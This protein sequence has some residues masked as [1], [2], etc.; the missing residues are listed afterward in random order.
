MANDYFRF[1]QFTVAQEGCG[2][3][4]GTDGV[5][6]GAWVAVGA[7]EAMLDVGTGTGLI[8]LM[9][10]QRS[11]AV[12]DA[13]DVD[14]AAFRQARGNVSASPFAGR[15]KVYH[16]SLAAY[17]STAERRYDL[18]VSNPPYFV[19]SLKSPD[20]Q[21]TMAR[22]ADTLPLP[23]LVRDSLSLLT[24]NGRMAFI[25][26]SSREE[27]LMEIAGEYG[28]NRIRKTAVIP[29]PGALPK[30]FLVELSA[31]PSL[32]CSTGLLTLE[33]SR[34]HYTPA[35]RELTRDFYLNM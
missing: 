15:I 25:L 21:R 8:A 5:L 16:A 11:G 28:L 30:R 35:Y 6:L 31:V 17:A 18:V 26:P 24:P 2:M 9:L 27:E 7:C 20:R 4:V 13:I 22:H 12:V 23:C 1:K 3:K 29:R 32:P 33:E 34:H 10:A 19:R 14:E